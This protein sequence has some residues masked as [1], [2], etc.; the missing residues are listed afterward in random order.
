[1]RLQIC[2]KHPDRQFVM[3][4]PGCAQDCHDAQ[5]GNPTREARE[6]TALAEKVRKA[7]GRYIYEAIR[8]DVGETPTRRMVWSL[9]ELNEVWDRFYDNSKLTSRPAT[10]MSEG[11]QYAV[12][13]ICLTVDLP[14]IG[15]VEVFTDYGDK[16]EYPHG[17][18]DILYFAE[19]VPAN[20]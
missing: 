17:V 11:E 18:P 6:A 19:P 12:T 14:K 8:T 16:S 4:C 9:R 7:L 5:Y 20:V 10:R 2:S 3:S 1:M 15:T 13:E